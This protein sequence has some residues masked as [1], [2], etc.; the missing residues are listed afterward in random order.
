MRGGEEEA[1]QATCEMVEAAD[2]G[3]KLRAIIEAVRSHRVQDDFSD[4]WSWAKE[5]FER[6]LYSKRSKSKVTFVELEDTIPMH[7]ADKELD[8]NLLWD[9]VLALVEPKDRR[10]VVCL[11]SGM[12]RVSEIATLLGYANHS[13]VSKKLARIRERARPLLG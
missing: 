4:R 11:R 1:W 8:E 6:K 12:T 3:G 10:V 13:A 9:D 2:E 7:G 5:D